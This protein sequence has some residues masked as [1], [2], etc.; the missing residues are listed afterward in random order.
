MEVKM[1]TSFI[2]KKPITETR[3]SGS[4]ISL[5]LLLSI[6]VF[7]ITLALTGGVW[8]WQKSLVAQIEKDKAA[9]EATKDSYEKNTIDPLIRLNDRIEA[10][11][12]LLARHLAISPVFGFL[13]ENIL[14]N[15]S[16]KTMNFTYGDN[17]KIK[18][19]L[20]G[21][22]LNYDALYKQ[23]EAFGQEKLRDRISQPVISDFS[24]TPEGRITFSF[25]A[26]VDP[27]LISYKKNLGDSA[28][29]PNPI[30]PNANSTFLIASSSLSRA[31]TTLPIE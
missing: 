30:L 7:I 10:A 6:I 4:G 31:S 20:T 14:R 17:D 27:R 16:L 2:P 9:L 5:F 13:E 18:I 12:E 23:A 3:G 25:N 22:A 19:D 21:T 15:V 1:Q 28:I 8:L 29:I 26:S 24:L 11:K